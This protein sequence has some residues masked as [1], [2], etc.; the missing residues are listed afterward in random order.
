M[1]RAK[2]K[3]KARVSVAPEFEGAE[4]GDRRLT[5]RL[6]RIVQAADANPSESFPDMMGSEAELEGF[7]RFIRNDKVDFEEVLR[8]HVR[9]T[10]ARVGEHQEVLVVHDTTEFRFLGNKR[11]GLGK[12]GSAGQGFLGHFSLAVVS[13]EAREPLGLLVVQPWTRRGKSVSKREKEGLLSKAEARRTPGRE[14]ERWARGVST[15]E[16]VAGQQ[17]ALIHVMDSE[18]DDYALLAQLVA[19]GRRFVIR[20]ARDRTIQ[21]AEGKVRAAGESA[22]AVATRSVTLS[23]RGPPINRNDRRRLGREERVAKLSIAARQLSINRPPYSGSAFPKTLPVNVIYVNEVDPPK[24]AEPV[25]WIL[26]TTEPISTKKAIL[27]IVDIYR[28]RWLIEEYFK[29]L[30]TGC[31]FQKRQ[32]ESCSTLLVALGIFAPIAWGLLRLRA[33]SR[34]APDA[35]ATRALTPTQLDVLRRHPKSKMPAAAR[36]RDALL[37]VARLG[38]HLRSN[39][40]PGWIVLGRGYQQLLVLEVG[41]RM[42]KETCDQS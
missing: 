31:D 24:N 21:E 12:V 38:G 17:A 19:E 8:P 25:E 35:P 33:L 39:G 14:S 9:A 13:G 28:S 20:L 2:A 32:L 3:A 23:R 5:T 42:G 16:E 10:V 26:F 6:E 27:R 15:A 41:F 18:A 7:Y 1:A 34:T 4:L 40:D 36:V 29:A 30:K 11:K 37:A 22:A